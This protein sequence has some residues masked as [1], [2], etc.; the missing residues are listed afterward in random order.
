MQRVA[1]IILEGY[2]PGFAFHTPTDKGIILYVILAVRSRILITTAASANEKIVAYTTKWVTPLS[3]STTAGSCS[4]QIGQFLVEIIVVY[5]K[6]EGSHWRDIINTLDDL[7][8][9]IP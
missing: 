7:R 6:T 4:T 1:N 2:N 5:Q 9:G 8:A 3:G